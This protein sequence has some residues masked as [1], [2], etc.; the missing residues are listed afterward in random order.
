MSVRAKYR[1]RLFIA[2]DSPNSVQAIINLRTVCQE[3]LPER[4]EIEL[5]DVL[6]EPQRALADSILL[7]PTLVKL[8]PQP[9][10]KIVG[11]LSQRGPLLAALGIGEVLE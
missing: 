5:V 4:H 9:V 11:N 7:T 8:A 2:G 3:Y 1:L 10:R 6:R